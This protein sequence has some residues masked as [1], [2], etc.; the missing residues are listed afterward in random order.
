MTCILVGELLVHGY[1]IARALG[2]PWRIQ[3]GQARVA[4]AGVTAAMP[5]AVDT[6]VARGV[7]LS[8]EVRVRGG[9]RFVCRFEGGALRVERPTGRPVDL[10]MSVDPVAY[11]LVSYG[12][13]GQWG[14]ML[15]G[16]TL[17]WGR[18]P[19]AAMQIK[20]LYRSV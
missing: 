12:R 9:P 2:R 4:I 5:L 3:P 19:W 8:Y 16:K 18:K 7:Q 11:L 13:I 15:R 17:V 1:D 20:R 14:P 10:C 6:E